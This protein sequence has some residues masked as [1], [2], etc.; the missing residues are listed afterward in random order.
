MAMID[1]DA[2]RTLETWREALSA[3]HDAP[4][5][6]REE[7]GGRRLSLKNIHESVLGPRV[8]PEGSSATAALPALCAHL[9][10]LGPVHFGIETPAHVDF[11]SPNRVVRFT[12]ASASRQTLEVAAA[13][14]SFEPWFFAP[15]DS[16][17]LGFNRSV[18]SIGAVIDIPAHSPSSAIAV[19]MD[20]LVENLWPASPPTPADAST[21]WY[22]EKGDADLPLRGDA[23]LWCEAGL[24]LHGAQS[25]TRTSVKFVSA[26]ANRDGEAS[27][28]LAPNGVVHLHHLAPLGGGFG[29]LSVTAL[30]DISC[31]VGAE[32]STSSPSS[33][34]FVQF[35]CRNKPVGDF[36]AVY[37]LPAR[38]RVTHASASM[39]ELLAPV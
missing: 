8:A 18:A 20:L 12:R 38:V 36:I 3:L 13:T 33:S 17:I 16:F 34:A 4:T 25:S 21:L 19:S 15:A 7:Q 11:A 22:I 30:V 24:S 5:N 28:D 6:L 39:C 1:A 9:I 2:L 29:P 10:N 35:E 27:T 23:V 32:I 14:G 31:F 37:L 26:W